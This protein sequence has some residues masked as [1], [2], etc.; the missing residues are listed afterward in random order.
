M[1]CSTFPRDQRKQ[2]KHAGVRRPAK[3]KWGKGVVSPP[4]ATHN[5]TGIAF[6]CNKGPIKRCAAYRVKHNVKALAACH[7]CYILIYRARTIVDGGGTQALH[8]LLLL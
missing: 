8:D 3:R 7:L 2:R 6:H 4:Q 5:V 1:M